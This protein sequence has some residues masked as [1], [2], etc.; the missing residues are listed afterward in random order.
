MDTKEFYLAS[1]PR[2]TI[3]VTLPDGRIITG[4]R[5][6]PLKDFMQV[7][8][9]QADSLIVGA[10]ADGN[11]RE[12]TFPLQKDA[13]VTPLTLSDA[14]GARIY[15]RS[16]TFLLEVAFRR[17]FPGAVLTIDHSVSSGGYYC[18]V[19]GVPNFS[20]EALDR[21]DATMRDLV[22]QDIPFVREVVPLGGSH[23]LLQVRGRG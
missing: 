20:Q 22:Q 14:D 12:L 1:N 18:Q 13:D 15:R 2:P 23:R 6:A 8:Q 16:L 7:I 21:L 3:E 4:Q 9:D 11:L 10:I 17:C 19:E 5:G